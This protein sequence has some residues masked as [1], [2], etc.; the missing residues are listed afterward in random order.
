MLHSH[1]DRDR[2]TPQVVHNHVQ[3]EF[4]RFNLFFQSI[5][6]FLTYVHNIFENRVFLFY[7]R[8]SYSSLLQRNS[9]RLIEFRL[10]LIVSEREAS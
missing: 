7:V 5:D 3:E 1:F 8:V 4:G 2:R 9:I 6:I 10:N